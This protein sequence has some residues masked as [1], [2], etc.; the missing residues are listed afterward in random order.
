[1]RWVYPRPPL[2][3]D[4]EVRLASYK[5]SVDMVHQIQFFLISEQPQ[6]LE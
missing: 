6:L 4:Q 2:T 3:F 5:P 1:M